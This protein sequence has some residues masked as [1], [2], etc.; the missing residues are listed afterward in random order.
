MI[1]KGKYEEA[2]PFYNRSLVIRE[3]ILGPEHPDVAITLNNTAEL[4]KVLVRAHVIQDRSD[5]LVELCC[6]IDKGP[7]WG[8]GASLSSITHNSRTYAWCRPPPCGLVSEYSGG[9]FKGS[10]NQLVYRHTVDS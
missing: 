8:G 9:Y 6:V 1:V 7:V 10:G 5:R 3:E 4:L 2:L